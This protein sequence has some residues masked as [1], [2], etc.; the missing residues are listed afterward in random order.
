MLAKEKLCIIKVV[1]KVA[2]V[3]PEHTTLGLLERVT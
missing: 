3:N 2:E 1:V